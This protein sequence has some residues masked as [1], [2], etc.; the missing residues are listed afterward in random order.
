MIGGVALALFF[1]KISTISF[2]C[3]L[4]LSCAFYAL[5]LISALT[6]NI[7]RDYLV[8]ITKDQRLEEYYKQM[9]DAPGVIKMEAECYHYK[10]DMGINRG[11]N[12]FSRKKV[13][14]QMFVE[15][16]V[17]KNIEFPYN[18]V[19]FPHIKD[20]ISLVFA[21]F[22]VDYE[23]A[24]LNSEL[25]FKQLFKEFKKKCRKFDTHQKFSC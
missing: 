15:K 5:Y 7:L 2:D 10:D 16:L 12:Y 11:T 19:E 13:I 8:H 3:I 6:C 9:M 18:S 23:F 22:Y 1:W 4:G 25:N 14:S 21:R 17:S 24:N 20:G